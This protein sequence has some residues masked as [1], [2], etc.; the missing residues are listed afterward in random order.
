MVDDE[1]HEIDIESPGNLDVTWV[2]R[3]HGAGDR[4]QLL[5]AVEAVTLPGGRIHTFVHGEAYEVRAVRRHLLG[6][7]QIPKSGSSISPYWR[8]GHTDEQWREVKADWIQD[9]ERDLQTG[10]STVGPTDNAPT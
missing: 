2:H 4:D 7:R 8:R 6:D 10:E 1:D 9:T 5:R 3:R